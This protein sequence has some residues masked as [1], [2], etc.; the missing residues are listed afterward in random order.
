MDFGELS[1]VHS[2]RQKCERRS[3]LSS[4]QKRERSSRERRSSPLSRVQFTVQFTSQFI[5]YPKFRVSLNSMTVE[6]SHCHDMLEQGYNDSK[7]AKQI[8]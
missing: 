5:T 3:V 1:S 7:N 4:L 8:V 6:S 2:S